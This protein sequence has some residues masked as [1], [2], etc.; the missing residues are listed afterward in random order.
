VPGKPFA[1]PSL[2]GKESNLVAKAQP[3]C[4]IDAACPRLLARF[5]QSNAGWGLIVTALDTIALM[6]VIAHEPLMG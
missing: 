3:T 6:S 4:G 2:P 5:R 1:F